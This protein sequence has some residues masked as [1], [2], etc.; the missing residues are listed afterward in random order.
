MKYP[1]ECPVFRVKGNE[2]WNDTTCELVSVTPGQ[3]GDFLVWHHCEH[4]HLGYATFLNN[5][6]P[7][8]PAARAMLRIAKAGAR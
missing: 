3:Y 7:L 8:T 6:R 5:L 1:K 2:H 4:P